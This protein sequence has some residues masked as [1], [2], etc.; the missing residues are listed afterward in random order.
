MKKIYLLTLFFGSLLFTSNLSAQNLI[1]F[2]NG[3]DKATGSYAVGETSKAKY[4]GWS[5]VPATADQNWIE[6]NGTSS[7]RYMDDIPGIDPGRI[8]YI[9]WDGVVNTSGKYYL[10]L[11]TINS[12]KL[13]GGHAYTFTWTYAWNS[14]AS[15]PNLNV[16]VATAKDGTGVI[17]PIKVEGEDVTISGNSTIF[18]TLPTSRSFRTGKLTFLAPHD[19]TYYLAFGANTASLCVIRDLSLVDEGDSYAGLLEL[20]NQTDQLSLGD[21]S[22]VSSD[23]T[24][25]TVGTKPEVSISW[26]SNYPDIIDATGKV[27]QPAKYNRVVTLTATLS[28]TFNDEVF[29]SNKVFTAMVL[30]VVPTPMEIAQWDFNSDAI[31]FNDGVI[32]VTDTKSGFVGTMKNEA[33]IRTIGNTTQFNVLDLGNGT[34]YFDMGTEIGRAVY[35]LT[36]YSISGFFRIDETYPFLNSNGN[37]YWTFSNSDDIDA[38][39]N[40]YIIGSLKNQGVNVANY[41]NLNNTSTNADANAPVGQWHHITYVQ[42]G[43]TGT[44]YIDGVQVAQNENMNS[45]PAFLLPKEGKNGTDY[46]WLGRSNYKND[47]YLRQTLLYDFRLLSEPLSETDINWDYLNVGETLGLLNAAYAENPNYI[48]AE[49][50]NEQ[51]NLVLGDLNALTDNITLPTQGSLDPTISISWSSHSDLISPTGEVTRPDYFNFTDTLTA[52]LFKNGQFVIKKFPF[53]VI[54]NEGTTFTN[55]LLVRYDFSDF[56]SD[57]TVTDV[58][59]K[60]FKGVIK[61]DALVLTMGLTDKYQVLSLGDSIGYFDMGEEMGKVLYHLEDYTISA[62]YRIDPSYEEIGSPGNFLW[63]LS[64]SDDLMGIKTGAIIIKLNDQEYSIT[65]ENYTTHQS[66]SYNNAAIPGSWHNL[67]FTQSGNT[68]I[69]YFDGMPVAIND[70]MTYLPINTLRAKGQLGTLYNWIGR[71]SYKSDVYLRNTLVYDFRIYKKAL[72]EAEIQTSE[73][74]VGATLAALNTAFDE[75]LSGLKKIEDSAYEVYTVGGA[76]RINGLK[77]TEKV[78]IYDISGRQLNM[79]NTN[80]DS[81]NVRK[82]IYIVRINNFA[83]KV[84]VR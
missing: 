15:A 20:Q 45:I 40:G 2:W 69:L 5:T 16:T 27:T 1:D 34:G 55:D 75:G 35:S 66:I 79:V 3:Y 80:M 74:N 11:D 44:V 7:I 4:W 29:T 59:E 43:N 28:M 25:P 31:T 73:L 21:L 56:D 23:I 72:T 48:A 71:S 41:W 78:A 76:I 57:T 63:N 61:N 64:N 47:V 60:K 39:R 62:Y 13:I 51:E 10:R 42:L 52:T 68:G 50:F 81:F 18:P 83:T 12:T 17:S 9:R 82:G 54:A 14:N 6:A 70:A 37:F 67:T 19:G 77:G 38:D 46:N 8:L 36:N 58:A 33:K 53:T 84:I 30:G 22:G 65:P 24:L 49:L 32:Q 26:E